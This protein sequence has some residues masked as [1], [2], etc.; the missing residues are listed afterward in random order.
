MPLFL[1]LPDLYA[2]RVFLS[3]LDEGVPWRVLGVFSIPCFLAF[4]FFAPVSMKVFT[5]SFW[6][7]KWAA[8]GV[9]GS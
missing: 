5:A 3:A 8:V 7:E 9:V 2:P 4:F 1:I 6:H